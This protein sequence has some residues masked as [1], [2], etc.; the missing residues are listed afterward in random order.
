MYSFNKGVYSAAYADLDSQKKIKGLEDSWEGD[1][2]SYQVGLLATDK[3]DDRL[4]EVIPGRA[5]GD[6]AD[7]VTKFYRSNP[8][9]KDRPVLWALSVALYKELKAS[10]PKPAKGS[11]QERSAEKEDIISVTLK[12]KEIP[13]ETKSKSK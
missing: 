5:F 7:A 8:L 13:E 2:P 3:I 6:L 4:S 9:L 11:W 10:R 12:K 1:I